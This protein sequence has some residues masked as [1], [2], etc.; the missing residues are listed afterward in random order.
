MI[1]NA[2][3]V[4]MNPELNPLRALPKIVRFQLMSALAPVVDRFLF[5]RDGRLGGPLHGSTPYCWLACFTADVFR[6]ALARTRRII[7]HN[8]ATQAMAAHVTMTCGV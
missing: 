2:R 8:T 1:H 6:R 7:A 4:V 3:N 5:G